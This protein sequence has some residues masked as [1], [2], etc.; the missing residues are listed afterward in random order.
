MIKFILISLFAV[1]LIIQQNT[2]CLAEVPPETLSVYTEFFEVTGAERQ[3]KQMR[4]IIAN[5]F[6]KGSLP[7][8]NKYISD[9]GKIPEDKKKELTKLT[10]DFM[11]SA[12]K[13]LLNQYDEDLPFSELVKNV[14]IP[15]Y[16]KYF[17]IQEIRDVIKF[18]KSPVG[19]KFTELTPTMM[20]DVAGKM[21]TVYE[22]KIV[23]ISQKIVKEELEKFKPEFEKL[24]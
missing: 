17:T 9:V 7:I 16:E 15:T 6:I 2:A 10:N 12:T 1:F 24:K 11:Q 3:Y 20:Q 19:Q 23:E 13:L 21:S 5:Q 4:Q 8:I 22:K 14:F 18:Y